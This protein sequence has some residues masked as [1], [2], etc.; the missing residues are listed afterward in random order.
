MSFK[1]LKVNIF[2]EIQKDPST[3]ISMKTLSEVSNL[4]K[5]IKIDI[6]KNVAKE[7]QQLH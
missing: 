5:A 3:V 6:A 4:I 7:K 2:N 1:S